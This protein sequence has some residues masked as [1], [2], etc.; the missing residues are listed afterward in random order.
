MTFVIN[1]GEKT[2]FT[3]EYIP[4]TK[5]IPF[6]MME[7]LFRVLRTSNCVIFKYKVSYQVTSL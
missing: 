7:R 3:V 1:R 6:I 5:S 2:T 4:L